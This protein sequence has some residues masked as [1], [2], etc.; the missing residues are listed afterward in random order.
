[1]NLLNNSQ[2][3]QKRKKERKTFWS[4]TLFKNTYVRLRV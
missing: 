4:K 1:M 2:D 3:F